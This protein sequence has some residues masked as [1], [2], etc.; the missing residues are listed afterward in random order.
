[1]VNNK[2]VPIEFSNN[3]Y[4]A[5]KQYKPS[6]IRQTYGKK[7]IGF[8]KKSITKF[9]KTNTSQSNTTHFSFFY[10]LQCMDNQSCEMETIL[11]VSCLKMEATI[12]SRL[13]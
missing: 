13:V 10:R 1:M 3:E 5:V 4:Q 9:H 11:V 8:L 7:S 12:L 2:T 6:F